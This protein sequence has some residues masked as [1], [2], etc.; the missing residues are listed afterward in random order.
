MKRS[1]MTRASPGES[2]PADIYLPEEESESRMKA[3]PAY[4]REINRS[5]L[6]ESEEEFHCHLHQSKKSF[7]FLPELMNLKLSGFLLPSR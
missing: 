1:L 5:R 4:L 6:L 2:D 3:Y 7:L